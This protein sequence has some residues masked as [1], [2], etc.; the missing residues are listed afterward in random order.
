MN[1]GVPL[2]AK[3]ALDAEIAADTDDSAGQAYR[4]GMLD[5]AEWVKP[6]RIDC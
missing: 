4:D 3:A 5:S 1:S 2:S 6:A